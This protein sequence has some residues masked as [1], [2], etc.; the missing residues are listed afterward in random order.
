MIIFTNNKSA[1]FCQMTLCI[2]RFIY[3]RKVV[4][5]CALSVSMYKNRALH[6]T[7]GLQ[8]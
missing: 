1:K 6:I 8:Q 7:T 3:K 2:K 4:L 5:F